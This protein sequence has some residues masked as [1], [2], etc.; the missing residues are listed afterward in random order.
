MKRKKGGKLKWIVIVIVVLAVIGA[1]AGGG[2]D[3]D[4]K[5][6]A[7]ADLMSSTSSSSTQATSK[8]KDAEK[9]D[10][11]KTDTQDAATAITEDK[12]NQIQSGMTYEQVKGI[13]G[14][15]GENIS[16]MDIAGTK[17]IMYQWD[18]DSWG[19]AIITFQNDQVTDK[20]QVG[21][22]KGDDVQ[23]TMDMYNQVTTG[24]TYD[25]VKAIFGGEGSVLSDSTIADTR[26]QIYDW[27][28]KSLGSSCSISFSNGAVSS[29]SQAGLE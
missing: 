23:V 26:E 20:S 7:K 12:F 14:T 18:S 22:S 16:E 28:G 11:P 24:M 6:K 27:Y 3:S 8:K 13:I 4:D 21:I 5:K 2:S 9:T 10:T 19:N 1:V 15:D 17:T 29:K 25:Q